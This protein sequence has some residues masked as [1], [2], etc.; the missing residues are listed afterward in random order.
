MK[1]LITLFGCC[2]L[3]ALSHAA[4]AQDATERQLGTGQQTEEYLG[5]TAVGRA[6]STKWRVS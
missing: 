6:F 5:V 1:K 2:A 4:P 3:L